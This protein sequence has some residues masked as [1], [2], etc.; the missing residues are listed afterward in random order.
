[1]EN[2]PGCGIGAKCHI[3]G[4]RQGDTWTDGRRQGQG[5]GR[6][7]AGA[8]AAIMHIYTPCQRLLENLSAVSSPLSPFFPLFLPLPL[9]SCEP[10]Q[11]ISKN[12]S[13]VFCV[14][15]PF[16]RWTHA[17][18]RF[19]SLKNASRYNGAYNTPWD[20]LQ[21]PSQPFCRTADR[22]SRTRLQGL[23]GGILGHW[24]PLWFILAILQDCRGFPA[25]LV[26]C[27]IFI[28]I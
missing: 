13:C 20:G 2:T 24:W 23:T 28:T 10:Y 14:P 19:P 4:R 3:D 7:W 5:Q 15:S 9:V 17:A 11:R 1:M 6:T 26:H 16:P 18:R 25:F 21:G 22:Y 8:T 12:R 27:Y